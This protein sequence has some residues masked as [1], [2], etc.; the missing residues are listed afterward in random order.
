M[1]KFSVIMQCYLG[2]YKGAAKD[3]EAKLIR[4]VNSVLNQSFKGWELIVVA[5]GCERTFEIIGGQFTA[6]IECYLVS[7]QPMWS[8]ACRNFG[9]SKAKGDWIVYLDADDYIGPDHLST[10]NANTGDNDWVWFNDFIKLGE[11]KTMERTA[12]INQRFQHG[13]ANIAHRRSIGKWDTAGYGHDDRGFIES[14]KRASKSY[15]KIQTPEYVVC[16]IPG[17][18]DQ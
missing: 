16:H 12:L 3:R 4:A 17:K 14:L 9:I 10:I 5:D 11:N 7:K 2:D 1:P 15:E 6:G 13:T 8:G 18:I